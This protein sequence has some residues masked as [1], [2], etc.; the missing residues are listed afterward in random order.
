MSRIIENYAFAAKVPM[1]EPSDPGEAKEM[2]KAG[3]DLSEQLDTPRYVAHYHPC[4]PTLKELSK[5]AR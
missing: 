2:L 1:L 3:Y 5:R 4:F